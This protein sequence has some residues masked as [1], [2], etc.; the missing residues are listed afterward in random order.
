ME[1]AFEDLCSRFDQYLQRLRNSGNSSVHRGLVILDKS[2]HETN[3]SADVGRVPDV[4]HKL[5]CH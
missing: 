5:G 4:R 2:A 1:I 3:P